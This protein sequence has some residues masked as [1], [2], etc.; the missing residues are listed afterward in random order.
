MLEMS[1]NQRGPH[2]KPIR[3]RSTITSA[4]MARAIVPAKS[5]DEFDFNVAQ[6][7]REAQV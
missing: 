6:D 5:L 7:P 1:F 2:P 3:V 4:I